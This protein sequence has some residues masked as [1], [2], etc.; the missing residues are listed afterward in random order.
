MDRWR[1]NMNQ[2]YKA[3]QHCAAFVPLPPAAQLFYLENR[4]IT[5]ELGWDGVG[6]TG[7]I[8][9]LSLVLH[10]TPDVR[11]ARMNQASGMY[12]LRPWV[13]TLQTCASRYLGSPPCLPP[14]YHKP[15]FLS[16]SIV[17]ALKKARLRDFEAEAWSVDHEAFPTN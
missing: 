8:S 17:I 5:L 9:S 4:Y 3:S 10:S 15:R 14:R 12:R 2:S 7:L 11:C 6:L 1:S 13:H 16:T